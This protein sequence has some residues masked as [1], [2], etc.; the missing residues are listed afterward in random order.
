MK[1]AFGPWLRPVLGALSKA[2]SLRGTALNPFGFH[3]EARMHR[4]TLRWY[5]DLLDQAS[6]GYSA[7]TDAKWVAALTVA[8]DI[9]GYGPVR[10]AAIKTA[11]DA[12]R[13]ALA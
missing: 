2:K 6:I 8:N 5:E 12:A 1:R 9:R 13:V 11:R 3:S 7:I 4:D 10:E